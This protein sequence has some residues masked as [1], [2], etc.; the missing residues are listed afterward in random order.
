MISGMFKNNEKSKFMSPQEYNIMKQREMM[1]QQPQK[2]IPVQQSEPVGSN[3]KP[4]VNDGGLGGL[5]SGL[6]GGSGGFDISKILGMMPKPDIN[7]NAQV[8]K[9]NSHPAVKEVLSRFHQPIKSKLSH[10]ET[11][12]DDSRVVS[13][14]TISDGSQRRNSA[15]KKAGIKIL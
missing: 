10:T 7:P 9:I 5:L 11:Q 6:T 4:P 12:D 14:D 3:A 15:K 1:K 2:Q 13:D 8:P